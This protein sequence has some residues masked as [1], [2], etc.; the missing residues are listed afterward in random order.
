MPAP[1]EIIELVERFQENLASYTS[2]TYNETQLRREFIDPFFRALG[3]DIDNAAGHAEAYKDVIHED[4]IRIG[5]AMKAPDYCFR[6]GGRGN[7]SSRRRSPP[8]TSPRM[9]PPPTSSAATPGPPG[10]RFPSSRTSRSSPSTTAGSSRTSRPGLRGPCPVLHLSGSMPPAGTRSPPSSPRSRPQRVLRP[11]CRIEPPEEG[12]RRRGR[13]FPQEIE[14][15]R[16]LLA[17]NIAL[18]NPGTHASGSSTPPCTLTIDRIIFLRI[19]EDRGIEPYGQLQAL[20]NGAER[21]SA[22]SCEIF[23]R[24]DDRYNSGLFHFRPEKDRPTPPDELTLALAI[25]DKA[26]K[27]IFRGLYYPDSPYEFSVLPADI[28]GRVYEQFLGKVIRL[29]AGHQAKVEDKPEVKKAGGVYYTPKYIVDYIVG[30]TVGKLLDRPDARTGRQAPDPRSRLRL[31]LIS[32]PG[33]PVPPRLV[34]GPVRRGRRRRSGR[35]EEARPLSGRRRRVA[36]DHG[37]TEADP[38]QQHL[39]RGH[40]PPGRRGDE[41]LAPP[42]GPGGGERRDPHEPAQA[43]PRA[44]L[45]RSLREHPVREFPDRPGLL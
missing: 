20:L 29:T 30:E 44:R 5:G 28:L 36:A 32:H 43:L 7:S 6:I 3:W 15:W 22:A 31:R 24:A 8:S 40:R 19:C 11:L 39:R 25:D 21:I 23:Y 2:G 13:G 16:D 41:A 45:A 9:P 14:S 42:Q 33:L 4:A 38:A 12:D 26:L 34:P 17:R 10:C 27:E 35:R 18:R 1:H 37:G